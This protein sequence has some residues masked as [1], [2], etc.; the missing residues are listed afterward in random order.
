VY[1]NLGVVYEKSG[2]LNKAIE[3]YTIAAKLGHEPAM[4]V[5]K[6]YGY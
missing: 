4:K 1:N 3:Y 2:N 6:Y 5:L